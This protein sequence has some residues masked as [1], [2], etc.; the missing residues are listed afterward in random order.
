MAGIDHRHLRPVQIDGSALVETGALDAMMPGPVADQIGNPDDRD[1]Q[2]L[3][4]RQSITRMVAM[5]VAEQDMRGPGQSLVPAV[6][7]EHRIPRQPGVDQQHSPFNLDPEPGMAKPDDFHC[8]A[9]YACQ[10]QLNRQ[11]G[12]G[13]GL[14]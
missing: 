1:R 14:A 2:L 4:Q 11:D 8:S 3:R 7:G 5:P 10:V 9:P 13:N 12:E 6:F